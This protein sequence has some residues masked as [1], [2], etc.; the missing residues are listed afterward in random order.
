MTDYNDNTIF[1]YIA[2]AVYLLYVVFKNKN[3]EG[4]N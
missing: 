4:R 2:F 3:D 1:I